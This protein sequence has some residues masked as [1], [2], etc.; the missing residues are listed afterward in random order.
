MARALAARNAPRPTGR[1]SRKAAVPRSSSVETAPIAR[2]MAASAPNWPRFFW[3]WLTA[4]AVVG[5]GI[6]I[7]PPS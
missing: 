7:A 2:M 4:S 5:V 3:T 6:G 1:A